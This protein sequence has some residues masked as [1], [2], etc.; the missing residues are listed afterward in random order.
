MLV[1]LSSLT[2]P[3]HASLK[4]RL[5]RDGGIVSVDGVEEVLKAD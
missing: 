3:W 5:R 4:E 1:P 2:L